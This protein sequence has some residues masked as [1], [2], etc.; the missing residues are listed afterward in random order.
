VFYE[1]VEMAEDRA[2]TLGVTSHGQWFP[3]GTT[4]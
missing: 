2:G 3:V 1:L 4:A